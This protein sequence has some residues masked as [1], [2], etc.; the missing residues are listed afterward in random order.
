MR[1]IFLLYYLIYEIDIFIFSVLNLVCL[2][3]KNINKTNVVQIFF[4]F[5]KKETPIFI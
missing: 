5:L 3:R 2:I 4:I 1:I